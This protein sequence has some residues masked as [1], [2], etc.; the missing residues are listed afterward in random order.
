MEILLPEQNYSLDEINTTIYTAVKGYIENIRLLKIANVDALIDG[1]GKKLTVPF[2]TCNQFEFDWTWDK[3]YHNYDKKI[4]IGDDLTLELF[5]NLKRHTDGLR[6]DFIF[7][8]L[9]SATKVRKSKKNNP[10]GYVFKS[11]TVIASRTYCIAKVS[12]RPGFY[13]AY[14]LSNI[15]WSTLDTTKTYSYEDTQVQRDKFILKSSSF[16]NI[17]YIPERQVKGIKINE[18]SSFKRQLPTNAPIVT[19]PIDFI[20]PAFKSFVKKMKRS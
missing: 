11:I 18:E 5:A 16:Y 6:A 10:L 12:N 9:I 3:D 13:A 1:K 2:P 7:K 15:D 19:I 20:S 14:F 4:K 17:F 8:V